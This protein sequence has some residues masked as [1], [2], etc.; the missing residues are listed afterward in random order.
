MGIEERKERER[1]QRRQQIMDA[2]KKI[3]SE[4]G[5]S[6]A[7]MENIAEAAELSPATLYLYYKNKDELYASFNVRMLDILSEK[8]EALHK[9][10]NLSPE[11]K[12]KGLEK[13]LYQV[14]EAD[15]LNLINVLRFQS[16]EALRNLSPELLD[17]IKNG[18][19]SYLRS[20]ANIFQDGVKQGV[21]L[22]RHPIAFADI[23]W[24]LFAGLVLWEHTKKDA[25]PKKDFL[26]PTLELAIEIF[27]R[28]IKKTD[29]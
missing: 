6:G 23:V 1:E 7:T 20:I 12:I 19:R 8:I 4:K 28:G 27:S 18:A 5:F 3:F 22:D 11:K 2:A 17:Q 25:D 10:N 15:P 24:G 29:H 16:S 9:K 13:A 26:K 21:F 14:Y